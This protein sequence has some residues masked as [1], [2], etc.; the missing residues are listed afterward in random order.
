MEI[1]VGES[2]DDGLRRVFGGG[3]RTL[4]IAT[5]ETLLIR[6]GLSLDSWRPRWIA[7]AAS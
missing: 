2:R 1:D 4:A 3:R 7:R 5:D 6:S